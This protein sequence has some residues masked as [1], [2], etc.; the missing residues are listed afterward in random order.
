MHGANSHSSWPAPP[1]STPPSQPFSSGY[2]SSAPPPSSGLVSVWHAHRP[3]D[4]LGAATCMIAHSLHLSRP[5]DDVPIVTA[6]VGA[7]PLRAAA[8]LRSRGL[9]V[10]H[11]ASR[12][13]LSGPEGAAYAAAARSSVARSSSKTALSVIELKSNRIALWLQPDRVALVLVGAGWKTRR[14]NDV[15]AVVIVSAGNG[16]LTVFDPAG[17]GATDELT[18]DELDATRSDPSAAWEV[19]LAARRA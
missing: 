16:A 14:D 18:F 17:D 5:G 9:T 8:W 12:A 4:T 19:L 15:H 3:A 10:G 1:D 7:S 13:R 11:A 6:A 2:H